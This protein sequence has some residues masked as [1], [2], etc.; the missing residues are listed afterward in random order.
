MAASVF[1]GPSTSAGALVGRRVEL[2]WLRT[3][4]DLVTRGFPHLVIV[5]G[6]QGIG[7]TRLAN[8]ALAH[9]RR[10]G[11]TVLRGRCYE[12]LDLAY[13]PLRESMFAALSRS[14]AAHPHREDD[15]RLLSQVRARSEGEPGA[16]QSAEVIE[17]ERTRQ[18]LALTELVI[19]FAADTPCVLFIDDLD[20]ADAATVDLLRHLLFRLDD[21]QVPLL[22]L[23]T[24]RADP[25]ARAAGA[26]AMLR[27]EPRTAV[28]LLHPLSELESTELARA[29]D[30][31]AALERAREIAAASG[32][33]PLLVEAL[34]RE[35][36]SSGV[37]GTPAVLGGVP[38]HPVTAAIDSTCR[39]LAPTTRTVLS[40]AAVL[41]PECTRDLLADVSG[42]DRA[43]LD[44]AVREAVEAGVLVD[45][46]ATLVFSHPLYGHTV[47]AQTS[48]PARRTL[49]ASAATTLQERRERGEHVGVRSI[50]QHVIAADAGIER[51]VLDGYVRQAGDEALALGAW[52]EAARC[53]EALLGARANG[54][55][56]AE[57]RASLHRLAGL[58]RRSNLQLAKA[59]A[60][61]EAAIDLV[62][63]EADAA[64]LA[65][66]HLWRIRS[67]IGTKEM[68]EVVADRGPLEALVDE[69]EADHPELAAESL[70]EL[71]QSY[72]VEWRMKEAETAARRAMAIAEGC[73]DHS[74]YARATTALCVPQWARYELTESLASLEDGVAHARAAA[75]ESV[76]AGGPL[77]RVPLVLTW[78]GRLDEAEARALECCEVA[79][80]A[81]YPLELGLPLAA[82]TQIAVL[83]GDF[84]Q[85]EQYAHRALLIQRLSG[86]HWAAG[87]F[88]PALACAHVARGQ[89]ELARE[90]LATWA[91]TADAMELATVELLS[92]Y[93]T[94]SERGLA[95]QGEPLPGLPRDPLVGADG[96]AAAAVVIARREGAPGDVRHAHDLL[97]EVERRG[98]MCTSPLV[99]LVPRILG[100]ARDLLGDEEGAVAV[101]RGAITMADELRADPERG[102]AQIA[103][104]LILLRRGERRAALE[105][106]DPAVATFRRLGMGPEAERATLLA[107]PGGV[108]APH[109]DRL[110]TN[111][112]SVIFFTDVVD[113]TR[114]TEE[115]GAAHYRARA[116]LLENAVTSAIVAHGGT[117]VPGISL[118]DG[119]IGLFASVPQAIAA[120]RQCVVDVGPT[121]LH[122][123]LAIH[124]GELIVDGPRVYGGAVNFAAR[125]CG[126]SGPDE[127]LVSAP[128]QAVAADNPR[129]M[130]VDRG[131]HA[132]KGIAGEQ[133]LY[134][135]VDAPETVD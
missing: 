110:E 26:V 120:A 28:V 57:E 88:L 54:T 49:H 117:I 5:E 18:L 55:T 125:V 33:N 129:V 107:G 48:V 74:A 52:S 104:A 119:F 22:V 78:L 23:A 29:L 91:E 70:V 32:G 98:G 105:L 56:T 1:G 100:T 37:P 62:G 60:H 102:R 116:R 44:R 50:A 79:E 36:G 115:L 41:V 53:Y 76:L 77:F 40:A 58:S 43:E 68:L 97:V 111:A 118:G 84:D 46:G 45:D 134:A 47:Y 15:V 66:L 61:F 128:I 96:W 19:E 12:H 20:W 9:A 64:T 31:S 35:V 89:F 2:S 11:A 95:V 71:S 123:H 135:L 85:A 8:E 92:R 27:S 133:R 72:W 86:Y 25:R 42:V 126:L 10:A 109:D 108:E 81:Q 101:L 21:E 7:K 121:G 124:Q 122:L 90:A 16:G 106:L 6:E 127:I 103:L 69:I 75:D 30:P 24:S 13:L 38:G 4:F 113:S 14:L 39:A 114:L 130:F 65:D 80:R 131:E 63:P 51:G 112:T 82:L 94:V 99:T 73:D 93:V 83:R 34:G 67:G 132:M 59:V 3:R 87:L 17:R